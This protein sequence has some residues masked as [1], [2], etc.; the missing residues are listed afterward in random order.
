MIDNGIIKSKKSDKKGTEEYF[1]E[2][3]KLAYYFQ[4][5]T[6]KTVKWEVIYSDLCDSIGLEQ[7]FVAVFEKISMTIFRYL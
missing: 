1:Y 3:N 5:T 7:K 2:A 6:S 4:S